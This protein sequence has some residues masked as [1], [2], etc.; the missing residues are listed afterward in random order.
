M[1]FSIGNFDQLILRETPTG[2]IVIKF[3]YPDY[4]ST[5]IKE[6]A[7][8]LKDRALS[9]GDVVKRKSS[10]AQSGMVIKTSA[11]CL[12]E[13]IDNELPYHGS[14]SWDHLSQDNSLIIPSEDLEFVDY[15]P[16]DRILYKDWM[17]EVTDVF[18]EISV[19][20]SN[21]TVVRVQDPEALEVPEY[22][23]RRDTPGAHVP[24][25][26]A[27]RRGRKH[28]NETVSIKPNSEDTGP[29]ISFYPGQTVLTTKANLRLGHWQIGSY[30]P[31]EPP[32]GIIVDVKVTSLHV[33]WV[34]TKLFDTTRSNFNRPDELIGFPEL[35]EI[36]LYNKSALSSV[37]DRKSS[38]FGS[39]HH[40]DDYS[41]GD[42]VKFR[43]CAGAAVKY[44]EQS[45]ERALHGV[46]RR[47]PRNITDGFDMNTFQVKNTITSVIIQWQDG[48]ISEERSNDLLAYL[49]VDEHDV[50]PGETVSVRSAEEK[51]EGILR[52]KEVG[53]VQSVDAHERI[54]KVRW[55]ENASAG[56][57]D[58]RPSN[59]VAGT[60]LGPIS[61][62]ESDVSLFDITA[63]PALTKRR[64][65]LVIL[66]P[67]P[68]SVDGRPV[69]DRIQDFHNADSNPAPSLAQMFPSLG[70]PLRSLT[71]HFLADVP[72]SFL[73]PSIQ[74]P[75]DILSTSEI[76]WFG[77]V[78]DLG[79]DG[80]LTVRLGALDRPEDIRLPTERLTVAVGGDDFDS[81]SDDS[82]DDYGSLSSDDWARHRDHDWAEPLFETFEY[83]GGERLDSGTEDDWM[84]DDTNGH[85][86]NDDDDDD[87]DE[88]DDDEDDDEDKDE[89]SDISKATGINS[90]DEDVE[91]RD[92]SP[93]RGTSHALT[94]TTARTTN[95]TKPSQ[96]SPSSTQYCFST[97][98]GMPSQFEI[99]E[100][101][102]HP[103][104]HFASMTPNFSSQLLRRVRREHAML[105]NNL[106]EGIWIRT[107]DDRLDLLR[108]L[109]IGPRG[110]P[111]ELAPFM[112]DF[113]LPNDFPANPPHVYFHSWTQSVG[114]INPNLYE[115]GKVC[116]SI[117]GTWDHN[118]DTE[119]WNPT[120]S[121]LLQVIVS[122]LGLVLV[123]EP[124]YSELVLFTPSILASQKYIPFAICN[125]T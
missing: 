76:R 25:V 77:E 19:R 84:T 40:Y 119:G 82:L 124:Y 85:D 18:E 14:A 15:E 115:D 10:D 56:I 49:N 8:V 34:A 73:T 103:S 44:S 28:R 95:Q 112:L 122:L 5:L 22:V 27:L 96:S 113:K 72:D 121:S 74:D 114:R 62:R 120:K 20:L 30:T 35:E 24:L 97:F 118:S 99:L 65:D 7:L 63:Y 39:R 4:G 117:L 26:E 48:K 47:I 108:V 17:G 104:H 89:T 93:E 64:G 59:L 38:L 98:N 101:F 60:S 107:W 53:V 80:L 109:I 125:I 57:H 51:S 75:H 52:L 11:S 83:E 23:F 37:A 55:F 13:P 68:K 123:E 61:D 86:D 87:D 110:T 100:G 46:F 69:R 12:L 1:K 3:L 45:P 50:W 58:G 29:P 6:N 79:L 88:D 81:E 33:D 106:P 36:R 54:A 43:D 2:H 92:A 66:S 21:G 116:L 90:I 31:S 42:I 67:D 70:N 16:G 105:K 91:M 71:N 78:V 41:A 32:R 9:V 102:E 94:E 111:Y